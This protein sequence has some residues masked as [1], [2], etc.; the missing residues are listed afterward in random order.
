[1]TLGWT[2]LDWAGLD[3]AELGWTGLDWAG[4][5]WVGLNMARTHQ[6]AQKHFSTNPDMFQQFVQ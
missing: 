5:D 4:L 1:M 3:W 6:L 2:G